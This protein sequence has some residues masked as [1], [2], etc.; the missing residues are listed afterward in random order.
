MDESLKRFRET[1]AGNAEALAVVERCQQEIELYKRYN[2]YFGYQFFAM[3][4]G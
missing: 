2:D 4:P 3:R 1:F